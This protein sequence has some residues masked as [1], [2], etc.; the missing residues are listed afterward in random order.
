MKR[1]WNYIGIAVLSLMI[2]FIMAAGAQQT[3]PTI[4]VEKTATPD[5]GTNGTEI[6]YVITITNTDSSIDVD[7]VSISDILPEGITYTGAVPE[8]DSVSEAFGV[9][10]LGWTLLDNISPNSFATITVNGFINGEAFGS[11]T[12]YVTAQ[13]TAIIDGVPVTGEEVT[14]DA[15]VTANAADLNIEST[16]MGKHTANAFG[17]G[18]AK[19]SVKIQ[20]DQVTV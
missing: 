6:T 5:T 16:T 7:T 1:R 9:T 11:L 19:N 18:V 15:T 2:A 8:P 17:Q 20:E 12:N 10:T 3:G 4:E 14:T 13:A